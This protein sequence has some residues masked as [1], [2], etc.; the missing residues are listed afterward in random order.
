MR[1]RSSLF[2]LVSLT[3]ALADRLASTERHLDNSK[4]LAARAEDATNSVMSLNRSIFIPSITFNKEAKRNAEEQRIQKRY[5]EEKEER[6][7]TRQSQLDS[8]QRLEQTLAEVRRPGPSRQTGPKSVSAAGF[9]SGQSGFTSSRVP[10]NSR[11]VFEGTASDEELETR[12]D[13]DLDEMRTVTG[14]LN[15]VSRTMGAEIDEQVKRIDRI[16]DKADALDVK[17]LRQTRQLEKIK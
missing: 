1:S 9:R 17:L 16:G 5:E 11:Y 15:L 4:G 14:Q 10:Q 12:I 2:V 13:D 7:R 8:R 6:E 3:V